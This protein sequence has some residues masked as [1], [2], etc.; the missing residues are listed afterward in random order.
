MLKEINVSTYYGLLCGFFLAS[1]LFIRF[2]L[3]RG[4]TE[5]SLKGGILIGFPEFI[6]LAARFT[7]ISHLGNFFLV[8]AVLKMELRV[9]GVSG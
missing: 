3:P 4:R 1:S 5:H 7:C 2:F 8:E 6:L 9:L